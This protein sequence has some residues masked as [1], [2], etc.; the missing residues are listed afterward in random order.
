MKKWI[1]PAME[2]EVFTS[3]EELPSDEQYL[4]SEANI[5]MAA[6]YAPYSRF[7]VGAALILENGQ[8]IT[9]NNQENMAYP[10]GLCAER[11]AFYYAGAQY[12]GVTIKKLAITAAA[13]HF[14]SDHPIAP[15]GACRQSMLEYELNQKEPIVVLMRGAEGKT[16]R[17][18]G[19]HSMLPL[20]FNEDCLKKS[21]S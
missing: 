5:A 6:A 3:L 14:P 10:S 18:Q 9:G 17:V 8:V 19:I 12:P 7:K 4:L 13:E 21:N 16:Y 15:C 11:V 2:I 20:F 1:L